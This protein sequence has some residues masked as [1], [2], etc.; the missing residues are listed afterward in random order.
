MKITQDVRDYAAQQ[1]LDDQSALAEVAKAGMEEKAEEFV[2]GLYQ[3]ALKGEVKF[4]TGI[5]DPYEEPLN[6]ELVLDSGAETVEESFAKL[7]GKLEG[8][9]YVI[10]NGVAR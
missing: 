1:G 6:P 3:K 7:I 10:R 5:S 8:L 9:D 4:F 2:K